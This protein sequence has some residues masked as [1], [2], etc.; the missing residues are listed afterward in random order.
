MKRVLV[1]L[2]ITLGIACFFTYP[3]I[4]LTRLVVGSWRSFGAV[5]H[6]PSGD[7]IFPIEI[8]F[9]WLG[10]ALALTFIFW[11]AYKV[12]KEGA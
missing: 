4:E 8:V 9:I 2:A 12:S 11:L 5:I 3:V 10:Y 6:F 1:A 7:V